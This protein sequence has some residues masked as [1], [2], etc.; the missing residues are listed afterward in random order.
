MSPVELSGEDTCGC[1]S[2][3]SLEDHLDILVGAQNRYTHTHTCKH[4][5][6]YGVEGAGLPVAHP[7]MTESQ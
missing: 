7:I 5:Q 1:W 6:T 2:P 3:S 4:T